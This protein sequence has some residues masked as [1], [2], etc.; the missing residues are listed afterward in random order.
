MANNMLDHVQVDPA[1]PIRISRN[2]WD[3]HKKV[4]AALYRTTT[5][6][7]LRTYMAQNYQ[8]VASAQQWKKKISA[9]RLNKNLTARQTRFIRKTTRRR[10]V[11]GRKDTQFKILGQPIPSDK[12]KR[13]TQQRAESD[14]SDQASTGIT[15]TGMSYGTCLLGS[16]EQQDLRSLPPETAP[17]L[18]SVPQQSAQPPAIEHKAT[19]FWQGQDMDVL[20]RIARES[21]ELTNA[22]Q[23]VRAKAG[24]MEALDG[25]RALVGPAHYQTISVLHQFVEG[26]SSN[27]DV[28]TALEQ[29]QKS[30]DDHQ[31]TL[32]ATDARTWISLVR[33]G[34]F[35]KQQG[36]L[37]QALQVLNQA[38]TGLEE[39]YSSDAE[40][41]YIHT[42]SVT[43]DIM[44]ILE[45]QG[46]IEASIVEANRQIARA[47]ALGGSYANE[48]AFWKHQLAHLYNRQIVGPSGK[49]LPTP[50]RRIEMLLLDTV[51]TQE[52]T[53]SA[54][55][56][57]ICA[58]EQLR[59]LYENHGDRAKL[60]S[61]LSMAENTL[62]SLVYTGPEAFE[63]A[64][65]LRSGLAQSYLN[66]GEPGKAERCLLDRGRQISTC[67]H[68][69]ALSTEYLNNCMLLARFYF[70]QGRSDQ[71]AR[72]LHEAG[73]LARLILPSDHI[74][75][76]L[77]ARALESRTIDDFCPKCLLLHQGRPQTFADRH[78]MVPA[79]EPEKMDLDS[80]N[81]L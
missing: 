18:G 72:R 75:H 63:K 74:F 62:V 58:L 46:D 44:V 49:P 43:T 8:F 50:Y 24:F 30:Y 66:F 33:L 36:S 10:L 22:G 13:H 9:W 6:P 48:T 25:L 54:D 32:G 16:S 59:Q 19:A 15:P 3:R 40:S 69:G 28:P 55:F 81:A 52:V 27:D 21:T 20:V 64:L 38:R 45:N 35:H 31:H 42:T 12:I 4:I 37:S 14:E 34:T 80:D 56:F 70:H 41:S 39:A 7:A 23:Y 29:L 61:L 78:G 65:E 76:S 73:D 47:D 68:I 5:L 1:V 17:T 79:G 57:Y 67:R 53:Q 60:T 51:N 77:V 71:A 26:A 2:E 11:A